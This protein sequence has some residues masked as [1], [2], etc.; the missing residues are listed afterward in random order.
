M[1]GDLGLGLIKLAKFEDEAGAACGPYSDW[2]AAAKTMAA[3][4]RRVGMVGG[5]CVHGWAGGGLVQELDGRT[6]ACAPPGH[7]GWVGGQG[8]WHP[9]ITST[10]LQPLSQP[11]FRPDLPLFAVLCAAEPAVPGGHG[12]GDGEPGAAARRAGAGAGVWGK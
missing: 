4:T 2:G 12:P 5:G 7:D 3:D 6:N 10:H 1:L 9:L 8:G 11:H